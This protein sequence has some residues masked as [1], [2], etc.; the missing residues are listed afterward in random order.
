M[1]VAIDG[2]VGGT[3]AL[4]MRACLK[5]KLCSSRDLVTMEIVIN[6]L[7]FRC[8]TVVLAS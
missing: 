8:F 6:N 3:V 5:P 2:A 7:M 4:G 1:A